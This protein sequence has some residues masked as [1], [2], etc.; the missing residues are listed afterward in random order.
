MTSFKLNPLHLFAF[1]FLLFGFY[2]QTEA[3]SPD[4]FGAQYNLFVTEENKDQ[5]V[6][7]YK[8][9]EIL[10]SFFLG[11][12][13]KATMENPEDMM[14]QQ[15]FLVAFELMR[16][17]QMGQE[18]LASD[19]KLYYQTWLN[20]RRH[21]W[22]PKPEMTYQNMQEF[23]YRY[24]VSQMHA[25]MPY[26]QGLVVDNAEITA[27]K[28][29]KMA[30]VKMLQEKLLSHLRQ[31]RLMADSSQDSANLE[32]LLDSH[33]QAFLAV[34][35]E[36][37]RREHPTNKIPNMPDDIKQKVWDNNLNQILNQLTYSYSR[38]TSN[39][40]F[41]L[42][43]GAMTLNGR[44]YQPGEEIGFTKALEEGPGGLGGYMHGWTIHGDEEEW[45]YG[46]GLCGSATMFFTPS[47][48]AGLEIV[49][50]RGHSS[51]FSNLYPKESLGLDATIYFGSTDVI[52]KNNTSS[53][54]LYY[55]HDNKDTKEI[56]MYVI[57]NS[58]YTD[59]KIEGPIS[60]GYHSYKFIR[61]MT[62][63]DGTV[64]TEDLNTRYSRMY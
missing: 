25:G 50:R 5:P 11:M 6:P 28:Y 41:N 20:A 55:L 39:R 58:P 36:I 8:G 3:K 40:Q 10:E 13:L 43:K 9:I 29:G 23:L 51:Y 52:M 19:S 37:I 7:T 49:T 15:E 59:I 54:I 18:V 47:W 16:A 17:R 24:Q 1:A 61:H 64:V 21:N 48:R 22:L 56:T 27:D 31:V 57:G 14:S 34:E 63:P 62:K 2:G 42:V 38:D 32:V 33:Y 12:P 30:E 60:T 26:Y 4:G 53:P 35:A 46:G 44:V 45:E